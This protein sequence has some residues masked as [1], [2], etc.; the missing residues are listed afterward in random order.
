MADRISL[1]AHEIALV[2]TSIRSLEPVPAVGT[3]EVTGHVSCSGDGQLKALTP[4][5]LAPLCPLCAA[6][7]RWTLSHPAPAVVADQGAD[8]LP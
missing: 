7:V 4:G 2:G 1:D 8:Q 6:E 3:W 5:E